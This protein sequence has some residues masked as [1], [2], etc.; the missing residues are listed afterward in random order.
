[1]DITKSDFIK[2]I[3]EIS[4]IEVNAYPG[5]IKALAKKIGMKADVLRNKINYYDGYE[6]DLETALK[7]QDE[8]MSTIF[9][10]ILCNLIGCYP[11]KMNVDTDLETNDI[12]KNI[13]IMNTILI[14]F[15]TFVY[16]IVKEFDVDN[17][18]F[19]LMEKK[20]KIM[21]EDL[22]YEINNIKGQIVFC[23]DK[24][25]SDSDNIIEFK[26]KD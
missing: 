5:G 9:A 25:K 10:E 23:Y 8:T 6:L 15:E 20:I 3:S 16:E 26:K 12:C 21:R 22:E 17:S 13:K 18:K 14:R 7:I 24:K 4:R 2:V 19:R 11:I 1:M